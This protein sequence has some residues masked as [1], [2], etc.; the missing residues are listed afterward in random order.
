MFQWYLKILI[1]DVGY[2]VGEEI[3][4]MSQDITTSDNASYGFI[5]KFLDDNNLEVVT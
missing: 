2:T 3:L 4:I 1:A 5:V